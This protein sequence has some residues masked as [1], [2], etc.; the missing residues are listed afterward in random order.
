[1]VRCRH[2]ASWLLALVGCGLG[3]AIAGSI[4]FQSARAAEEGSQLKG[5]EFPDSESLRK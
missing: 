1:M 4:R 2:R 3:I 5:W